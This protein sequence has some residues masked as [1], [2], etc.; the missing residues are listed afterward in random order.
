MEAASLS[1][2]GRKRLL[3]TASWNNG[4]RKRLLIMLWQFDCLM[5]KETINDRQFHDVA[6]EDF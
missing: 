3:M 2:L 5:V 6:V 1:D 4:G